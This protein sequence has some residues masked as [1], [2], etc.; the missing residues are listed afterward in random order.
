[1]RETRREAGRPYS[2]QHHIRVVQYNIGLEAAMP[3][4]LEAVRA[5][6]TTNDAPFIEEAR[7]RGEI[8]IHQPYE[9]YSEENHE[10]W[11]QALR[12]DAA[13][14]GALRERRAS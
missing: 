9:L 5:G 4:T 14:L 6:L 7:N 2:V 3:Q 1:M 8:Y 12:A 13:P 11:R 10:A